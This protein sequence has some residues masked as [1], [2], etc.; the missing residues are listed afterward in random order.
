M[1]S[2]SPAGLNGQGDQ[3]LLGRAHRQ[4]RMSTAP[5]STKAKTP[6]TALTHA[7]VAVIGTEYDESGSSA[8]WQRPRRRSSAEGVND[9]DGADD[10]V[11]EVLEALD[12]DP[13]L[14]D[15]LAADLLYLVLLQVL[16]PDVEPGH[17]TRAGRLDVPVPRNADR[18]VLVEHGVEDR[19]VEQPIFYPV[20]N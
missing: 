7:T 14:E 20:L 19:L 6:V 15:R 17:V 10:V 13:V 3:S 4:T 1:P 16:T 2:A 12:R 11:V 8:S 5:G 18:V 9:L